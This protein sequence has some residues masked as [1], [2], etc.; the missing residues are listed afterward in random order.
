MPRIDKA[1]DFISD[2][3]AGRP[4][5]MPPG[6]PESR[7]KAQ[8]WGISQKLKGAKLT[9][10]PSEAATPDAPS[11]VDADVWDAAQRAAHNPQDPAH[12]IADALL[13]VARQLADLQ[14]QP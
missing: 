12:A 7:D 2:K 1:R 11:G 6:E 14:S 3:L 5:A 9:A 13:T 10:D 4:V 8:T